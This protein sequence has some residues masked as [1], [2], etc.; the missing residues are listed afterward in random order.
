MDVTTTQPKTLVERLGRRRNRE[1]VEF[2]LMIAPWVLGFLGLTVGP[3]LYSLY[4]SFTDY[5]LFHAPRWVGL[6]NFRFLF[7]E[8]Y[9]RSLF[10][11]SLSVTAYYTFFSVPVGILA[12]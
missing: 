6:G 8:P 3:M 12:R 1:A 4:L 5:D 11:K 9:P 10:W 7:S 2:Y